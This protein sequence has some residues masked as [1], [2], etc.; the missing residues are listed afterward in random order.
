M[1][2]SRAAG[3]RGWGGG[4]EEGGDEGWGVGG[5]G[6]GVSSMRDRTGK[7]SEGGVSIFVCRE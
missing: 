3:W 5:A 6:R 4:G 7:K 1:I 2:L